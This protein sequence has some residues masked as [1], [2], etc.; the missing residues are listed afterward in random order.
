MKPN[1]EVLD[2]DVQ[3]GEADTDAGPVGSASRGIFI[4]A[5]LAIPFWVIVSIALLLGR[6]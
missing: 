3:V 2:H 1:A 4:A 5:L 6:S